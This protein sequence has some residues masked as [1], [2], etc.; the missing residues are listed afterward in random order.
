M[1]HSFRCVPFIAS[2]AP[3]RVVGPSIEVELAAFLDAL[4]GAEIHRC[5]AT[6]GNLE[7][8][9][10]GGLLKKTRAKNGEP[11]VEDCRVESFSMENCFR[12]SLPI[13]ATAAEEAGHP[14]ISPRVAVKLVDDDLAGGG[15]C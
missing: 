8:K 14:Y 13:R 15:S 9:K 11:V 5:Q 7:V 12:G 4:S 1:G 2:Q 10:R 3:Q 6:G